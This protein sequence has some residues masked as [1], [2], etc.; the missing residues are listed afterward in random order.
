MEEE[1][2][3]EVG[4]SRGELKEAM[5][6]GSGCFACPVLQLLCVCSCDK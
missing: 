3:I 2:K 6:S 5:A 4:V 1:E